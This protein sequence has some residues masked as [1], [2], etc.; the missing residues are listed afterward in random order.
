[1][2]T[3][4]EDL[5]LRIALDA[6]GRN[7]AFALR[8]DPHSL[9]LIAIQLCGQ[10]LDVEDDFRHILLDARDCREFVLNTVNLDRNDCNARKRR[11]QHTAQTVA[12]R[13]TES[14]VQRFRYKF[15]VTAVRF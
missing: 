8:V 10:P 14:P 1:M 13:G 12:K 5:D 9:R 2:H 11:K 3:R 4:V 6:A 7:L 15:A